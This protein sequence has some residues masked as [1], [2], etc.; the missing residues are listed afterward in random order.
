MLMSAPHDIVCYAEI[1]R[2]VF[3][4][5]KEPTQG[6]MDSGLGAARRSGMTND[7]L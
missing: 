1:E 4:A 6:V 3:F 2:A 5:G 7:S